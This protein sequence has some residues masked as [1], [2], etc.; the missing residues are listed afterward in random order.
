MSE[1]ENYWT[2]RAFTRRRLLGSAS[3]AVAAVAGA[4][5]VGCGDDDADDGGVSTSSTQAGASAT[6]AA[7]ADLDATV[8]VGIAN[9][10]GGLDPMTAG[11][12]TTTFSPGLHFDRLLQE[13][14]ET[15]ELVP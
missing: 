8:R 3:V 2:R 1:R 11:N 12:F 15:Q 6:A 4:S 13:D 10:K 7:A 9:A 5:I 14:L